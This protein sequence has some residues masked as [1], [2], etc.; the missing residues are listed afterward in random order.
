MTPGNKIDIFE[1]VLHGK[2]IRFPIGTW[3]YKDN[4]EILISLV[5]YV[6]LDKLKWNRDEFCQKFCLKVIKQYK[7]NGG[8]AKVYK[9]N[10]YPLVTDS[11][12]EWDIKPWE[13]ESSRVPIYYW[14][15]ETAAEAT[16]WLIE[17]RLKWSLEK[18]S[19]NISN[20]TFLNNGLGGMLRTMKLSV[21][22]L[23]GLAYPN[24]DWDYLKNRRGYV[25]TIDQVR[26]IRR[27]HSEGYSLHEMSRIYSCDVVLIFNV[28]HC[29][30]FKDIK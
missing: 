19:K 1:D 24:Y 7:L 16:K 3:Y 12:P 9:R 26:E 15:K 25:L 22:E 17:T 6:V 2:L 8:F 14:T 28:V 4:K 10:I 18:V 29:I 5:R 21:P 27:L 11:F 20:S 30:T 13:M 23:V